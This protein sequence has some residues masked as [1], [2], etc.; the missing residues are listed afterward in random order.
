MIRKAQIEDISA[1]NKLV[2][3]AYRGESSKRGW[4]TEEHLLGGVRTTEDMLLQTLSTPSV[5]ILVFVE[6]E[7]ILGCV[8]L[9]KRADS[10]YLGM[11]TVSPELQGGGIGKKLLAASEAFARDVQ[12]EKITMTVISVRQELIAWYER[13]GYHATGEKKP[14]PMN[15][16]KFGEP[17]Q[18]LEFIVMEKIIV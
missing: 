6:K 17:K 9:E 12:S 8:S 16:P 5:S 3:S 4:T 7:A 11:L 13:C 2:N 18:F 14:F 15:N 1:L 10:L